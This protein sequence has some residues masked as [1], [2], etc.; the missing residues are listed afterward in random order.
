MI[1]K[2][3]QLQKTHYFQKVRLY[4]YE[5]QHPQFIS[6]CEC[7]ELSVNVIE[8][9]LKFYRYFNKL[10][11]RI[12]YMKNNQSDNVNVYISEHGW[13]NLVARSQTGTKIF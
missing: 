2:N 10:T 11:Y 13:T 12:A 7:N 9:L 8:N 6:C 3:K 1:F 4:L 5:K